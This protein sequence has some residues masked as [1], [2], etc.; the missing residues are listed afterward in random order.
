MMTSGIPLTARL[1]AA[2]EQEHLLQEIVRTNQVLINGFSRA[3]GMPVSRLLLMRELAN[4]PAA[5][6]GVLKIARQLGIN[7]AAVTRLVKQMEQQGFIKRRADGKDRRRS[8][9]TLSAKGARTCA[10][11]HAHG[12]ELERS[13]SSVISSEDAAVA[14]RVLGAVRISLGKLQQENL[15][16]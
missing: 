1:H 12:H 16:P 8:Y 9:L 5:G 14:V 7:A 15:V 3:V 13:L 6:I 11:L 4:A 2:G 10:Q